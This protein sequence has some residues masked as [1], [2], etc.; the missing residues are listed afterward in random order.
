MSNNDTALPGQETLLACWSALAQISPGARLVNTSAAAA[1]VF[2]SWAPLNNAIV[3]NADDAGATVAASELPSV[4][5]DAGID[6]W[7]LWI[8][9]GAAN[10]DAP[11]DLGEIGG[12]KR[13]TTTLVMQATLTYGLRRYER[14][15]PA[16]I[17]AVARFDEEPVPVSELGEPEFTPG[18]AGWAMVHDDVAVSCAWSFLHGN[19]CGIYAVGTLPAWRRQGMARSLVEHMLSDAASRGARTATLQSTRMGQELYESLGF[20]A[21]GRYEEW[22]P[23]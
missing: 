19:D 4:Y 21:V 20:E 16:S 17:A 14:V 9:S 12:M 8:P 18:L 23:Q 2:P 3:L 11:D 22:I 6:G 15:V 5:A 1:A 10:L 13:D 7:A